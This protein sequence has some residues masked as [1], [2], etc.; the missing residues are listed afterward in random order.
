M[1]GLFKKKSETEKLQLKYKKLLEEAHRLSTTNRSASDE[2]M[3]QANEVLKEIERI[4]EQKA[5]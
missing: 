3:F 5:E 4:K 2:K 1:F